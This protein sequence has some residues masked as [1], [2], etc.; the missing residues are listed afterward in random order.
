MP[1][2][3]RKLLHT[4]A[5]FTHRR[6]HKENLLRTNVFTHRNFC[7]EKFFHKETYTKNRVGAQKNYT[8]WFLHASK[9]QFYRIFS[10]LTMFDHRF[11][12][13]GR[14]NSTR[15]QLKCRRGKHRISHSCNSPTGNGQRD[16][17]NGTTG[18]RA[19]H[20]RTHPPNVGGLKV[21]I[22]ANL[23][24]SPCQSCVGSSIKAT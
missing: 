17:G 16:N 22:C 5:W 4:D 21:F 7:A 18:Q 12:R 24:D 3:T 6:F 13:N 10:C 1:F 15:K 2:Y 11:L 9:S 20:Y 23:S 14:W 8:E 19:G